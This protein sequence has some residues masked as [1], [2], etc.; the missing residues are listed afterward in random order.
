MIRQ[1]DLVLAQVHT[2]IYGSAR[3]AKVYA[4]FAERNQFS[5]YKILRPAEQLVDYD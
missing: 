5:R 1:T 4:Q 2:I 3:N